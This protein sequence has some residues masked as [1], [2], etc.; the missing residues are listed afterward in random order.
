MSNIKKLQINKYKVRPFVQKDM[1]T[2]SE[3]FTRIGWAPQYVEGQK[4]SIE[5]LTKDEAGDVFVTTNGDDVVG[6]IHVQH[7]RWN[8][9]SYVHGLVVSPDCRRQGI[10]HQLISQV[11]QAAQA[12]GN[13]GVFI[14]TPV[15]NLEAIAFY[16]AEGYV[17]DF[18]MP[19]Y[20]EGNIDGVTYRK[21]F[22]V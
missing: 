16:E 7:L 14:D 5:T 19:G 21:L 12:H 10:A 17:R 11:E 1:A 6:F 8:C 22:E 9:L 4:K 20:Y 18:I 2:I 15:N 13:R 3:I